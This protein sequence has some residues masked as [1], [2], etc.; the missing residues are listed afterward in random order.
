MSVNRLSP[1][2]V[3]LYGLPGA[4]KS[5]AL[6]C[7]AADYIASGYPV[8]CNYPIKNTHKIEKKDIN[9]DLCISNSVL[10]ID[11]AHTLFNSRSFKNFTKSCHE[12]FSLHRHLGNCIYLVTQH[13][14]RL[15]VVIREIASDFC[16]C[17]TFSLFGVPLWV[18]LRYY[19]D[20]PCRSTCLEMDKQ[21][22]AYKIERKLYRRSVMMSYDTYYMDKTNHTIVDASSLPVWDSSAFDGVTIPEGFIQKLYKLLVTIQKYAKNLIVILNK[23]PTLC[24]LRKKFKRK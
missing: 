14:A 17:S 16:Y 19:Y 2:V 20:D 3:I 8:C 24:I 7:L 1:G 12:F 21:L 4:G 22:K 18:T 9:T 15:D 5:Y 11:E 13:P 6:A 10:L 23:N